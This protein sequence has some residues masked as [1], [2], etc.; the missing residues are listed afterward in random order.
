MCF[1]G[2]TTERQCEVSKRA[3]YR[4]SFACLVRQSLNV[5][6]WLEAF[7][8]NGTSQI[9]AVVTGVEQLCK[10]LGS[11]P[12]APGAPPFDGNPLLREIRQ[13]LLESRGR[14]QT[15]SALQASMN[16]LIAL[17]DADSRQGFSE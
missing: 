2:A 11:G 3:Q 12:E 16:N 14:D 9:Q 5:F 7:V 10:E 17:F 4:E 6:Q 15:A 1:S 13:L 8:S